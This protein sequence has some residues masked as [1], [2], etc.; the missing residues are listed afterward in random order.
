MSTLKTIAIRHL[1]GSTD[2]VSLDNSG[3]VG[4]G[5][6][7]PS[8]KLHLYDASV[9]PYIL[10]D[11]SAGNRD[12][13]VKIKSGSTTVIALRGDLTGKIFLSSG[14]SGSTAPLSFMTNATERM[15]IDSSGRV[16]K[17]YQP[18]FLARNGD[19]AG[20]GITTNPFRFSNVIYNVGN[21]FVTSG[22]GAYTR[23]VA[24]VSGVYAF[25]SNP[26][27]K[28]TGADFVCRAA[29]N[30]A[31]F[32]DLIRLI[33]APNSH[34]GGVYGFNIYLNANDYVSLSSEGATYHR[35]NEGV[36]NWFSGV[37]LG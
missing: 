5:T 29:V 21:H 32:T 11:G 33:G 8:E 2:S 13:G 24:P 34:S 4:I 9:D 7:S 15:V 18:F 20:D 10:V 12:C 26:G 3:R 30:G 35:N 22:T 31:V 27:Y 23:F 36:P 25:T 19:Q 28:Q 14:T 16:T 37:L 6:A 17:P 1:N